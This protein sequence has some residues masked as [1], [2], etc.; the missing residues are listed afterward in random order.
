MT[1]IVQGFSALM[2]GIHVHFFIFFPKSSKKASHTTDFPRVYDNLGMSLPK[3]E[4]HP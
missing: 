2:H 3:Y 1:S 4:S